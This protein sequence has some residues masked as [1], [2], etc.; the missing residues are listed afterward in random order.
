MRYPLNN[1]EYCS[2][3]PLMRGHLTGDEKETVFVIF[4]ATFNLRTPFEGVSSFE[5]PLNIYKYMASKHN[6]Q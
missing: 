4:F 1:H 3:V 6:N 2:V 5:G